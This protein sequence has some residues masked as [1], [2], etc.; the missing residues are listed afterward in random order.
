MVGLREQ[1][2]RGRRHLGVAVGDLVF[3]DPDVAG[4]VLV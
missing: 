1:G 4:L 3:D 2:R